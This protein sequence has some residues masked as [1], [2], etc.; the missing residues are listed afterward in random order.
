MV[1]IVVSVLLLASEVVLLSLAWRAWIT[2]RAELP[3]WRNALSSASLL[4][5]SLNWCGAALL[6]VLVF[7]HRDPAGGA[8]LIE[9]MLTLSRP[10][11]ACA[12]VLAFALKR[13][14]RV[15]AIIAGLLM[16]AGW[17]LGYA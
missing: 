9:I 11:D 15:E 4:L 10:L 7:G 12:T 1:R 3:N 2:R 17:P 16:F 13:R 6:T 8:P 5:L 14:A